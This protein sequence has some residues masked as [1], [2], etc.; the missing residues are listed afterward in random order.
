MADD[1][2]HPQEMGNAIRRLSPEDWM[3]FRSR[4]AGLGA[5]VRHRQL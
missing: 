3:A 2:H 1:E 5:H 4:F